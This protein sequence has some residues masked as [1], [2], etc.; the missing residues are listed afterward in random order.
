MAKL[1]LA[2]LLAVVFGVADTAAVSAASPA[3]VGRAHQ[4]AA[5]T[6]AE[7]LLVEL[8]LPAGATEVPAEPAGD[9]DQLAHAD[10]LFFFAAEVERHEFWTTSASPNAVIASIAAHLP[11][12]ARPVG[13]GYSGTSV[14]ATYVLPAA[15]APALGPRGLDVQAV[16]LAGGGTGV[17]ADAAV[18]Y[19][20]PRLPSQ[21]VPRQSRVLSITVTGGPQVTGSTSSSPPPLFV[22]NRRDVERIAA[23]IDGLPFV[24]FRGVAISCPFIPA[25]PIDTFTFRAATAGPVLAKVTLP[26]D[27]PTEA[28]PCFTATLRIRG[29]LEP[30]LLEGGTL[31]RR[32]GAILGVK[33][34]A[35]AS[36]PTA[37]R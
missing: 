24:A 29:R 27:T 6:A 5:A 21:R 35:R 15:G 8:V 23:I 22:T 37:T 18:R 31:L 17:R 19:S 7:Q 4:R 11:A 9:A 30:G 12:G 16:A 3:Q 1:M 34:V 26:A 25:S 28:S 13:S 10:E 36:V 33:L 20:A 32:A 2:L 14:F